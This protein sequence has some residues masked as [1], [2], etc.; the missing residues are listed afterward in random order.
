M[1]FLRLPLIVACLLALFSP[2]FT[3]AGNF[4]VVP[5]KVY[6][7]NDQKVQTLTLHND[8]DSDVTLQFNAVE[9][10]QD[11]QGQD[12]YESTKALFIF[13]QI[14]TVKAGTEK[15]IKLGYQGPPAGALERTYR[16]YLT[17]LPVSKE[18]DPSLKMA[19]RLGVP[20]FIVPKKGKPEVEIEQTAMGKGVADVRVTNPSN[21]HV[22]VKTIQV[23]GLDASEKEVFVQEASGWYLLPG[24]HRTFPVPLPKDG[25]GNV[26]K[27]RVSVKFANHDQDQ[28]PIS[29]TSPM[30][31]SPCH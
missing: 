14:I 18:G 25:C 28:P 9:W 27:L 4:K 5:I 6:F 30:T 31:V 29:A 24:V 20:V 17:E 21:R 2:A 3:W 1:R 8:S 22:Y 7:E 19:L 23:A 26:G 10:R 13:P 16:V 15:P 12:M 11:E